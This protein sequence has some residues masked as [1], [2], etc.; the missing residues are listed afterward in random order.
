MGT[1][2]PKPGESL[3]EVNPE[4]ASQWHPT[5]NTGLTP[6]DI[7]KGC[8]FKVWWL[9]PVCGHEW[10]A[11]VNSRSRGNGCPECGKWKSGRTRSTP[12]TGE[13]FADL[14]PE[15]IAEWHPTRNGGLTPFDVKPGSNKKVWWVCSDCGHEWQA[16]IAD[17]SVGNGCP[18]CRKRKISKARSTPKPGESLAEVNPEL[19]SE[20][21]P[22][23]NG[24]L[25]PYDVKP[26]SGRKVWWLCSDC[27]HQWRTAIVNRLGGNGC[28]R[29]SS[30]FKTS[31]GE[32][33][34]CYYIQRFLGDENVVP[35]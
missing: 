4:L 16:T 6:N 20:W 18:E 30:V 22:T 14:H 27:G 17:R 26:G 13:S 10:Q 7:K 1:T 29:C 23:A 19:A 32:K 31:F 24:N 3:A 25:T 21:H 28:P 34:V 9:C 5:K 35:N 12:K 33:A 2:K 15:L 11:T 8:G